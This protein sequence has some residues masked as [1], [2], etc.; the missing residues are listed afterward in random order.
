MSASSIIVIRAETSEGCWSDYKFPPRRLG[1]FMIGSQHFPNWA[2][3]GTPKPKILF[4]S[5]SCTKGIATEVN[6]SLC[7]YYKLPEE[8]QTVVGD[9]NRR[10]V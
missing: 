2:T 1:S 3:Y 9:W 10:S 4:I 5:S 8:M 6:F 7:V